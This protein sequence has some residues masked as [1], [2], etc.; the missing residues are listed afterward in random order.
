M[1]SVSGFSQNG[2]SFNHLKVGIV[3][4]SHAESWINYLVDK[5]V[6]M[7]GDGETLMNQDGLMVDDPHFFLDMYGSPSWEI[8]DELKGATKIKNKKFES[9]ESKLDILFYLVGADDSRLITIAQRGGQ[10]ILTEPEMNRKSYVAFKGLEEI[11]L[12]ISKR[13]VFILPH[14]LCPSINTL[15]EGRGSSIEVSQQ[16]NESLK[17]KRLQLQ[18]SVS[19]RSEVYHWNQDFDLIRNKAECVNNRT[20]LNIYYGD[21]YHLN[22]YGTTIFTDLIYKNYI[23]N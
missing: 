20:P 10:S 8:Y 13:C 17:H 22:N 1:F 15:E 6:L 14:D 19:S 9:K 5:D 12:N 7:M 16:V 2:P 23:L 18:N 21:T 3:G 11:C 4:D